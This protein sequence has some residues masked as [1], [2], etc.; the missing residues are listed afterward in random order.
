MSLSIQQANEII[1]EIKAR[2]T[3]IGRD[4]S[5]WWMYE[6][7]IRTAANIAKTIASKIDSM[8]ESQAY[9]NALLHD[10]C[11]TNERQEAR[12]HGVTGYEKLINKDEKAARSALLH[13]FVW[14]KLQPYEKCSQMFFENKKDY[15]FVA[16]FIQNTKTSDEDLLIQLADNLSNKDGFVTIEQ[17]A[18]DLSERRGIKLDKEWLDSRYS[19]K[20]YFDK[21]VGCNIY[22]LFQTPSI[23][24]KNV[25][26]Y[27][28]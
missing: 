6:N 2:D 3:A 15:A 1:A 21:K 11:R 19:L 17:R 27:S 28:R 24:L 13:M 20:L 25:K 16:N 22:D 26:Q 18:Q 5:R 23:I 10:V 7:H 12:F 9:I 14:N 8:D 4:M